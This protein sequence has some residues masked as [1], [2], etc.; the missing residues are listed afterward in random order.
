MSR[1]QT[2][3]PQCTFAD[4]DASVGG[5]VSEGR[6][7]ELDVQSADLVSCLGTAGDRLAG[8]KISMLMCPSTG[9]VVMVHHQVIHRHGSIR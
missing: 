7:R 6:L 8:C 3:Q 5:I 2:V 4:R 1:S 9:S